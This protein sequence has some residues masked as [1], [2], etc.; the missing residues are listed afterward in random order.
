MLDAKLQPFNPDSFSL[1]QE[2]VERYRRL[3]REGRLETRKKEDLLAGRPKI[4]YGH[5]V[6]EPED[7]PFFQKP[8]EQETSEQVDEADE[9]AKPSPTE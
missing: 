3:A 2:S 1:A 6:Y 4:L 7:S 5:G 9:K 8:S